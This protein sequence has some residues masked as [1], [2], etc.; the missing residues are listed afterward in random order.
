MND[1]EV[2]DEGDESLE[3]LELEQKRLGLGQ[4]GRV[5]GTGLAFAAYS[6]A[7]ETREG[8]GRQC[9]KEQ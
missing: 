2:G 9:G 5:D 1:G 7:Y 6:R 8:L 3:D 4:Y